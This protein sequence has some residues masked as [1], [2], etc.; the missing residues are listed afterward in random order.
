MGFDAATG[1]CLGALVVAR[2]GG[3]C[4]ATRALSGLLK[5]LRHARALSGS[6]ASSDI[7]AKDGRSGW[8]G[9]QADQ[10]RA[11]SREL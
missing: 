3:A 10:I 8:H 5:C 4:P 6:V 9:I 1:A 2:L 11:N 7:A